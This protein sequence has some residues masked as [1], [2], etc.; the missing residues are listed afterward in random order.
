MI[1]LPLYV[2]LLLD[3]LK[4]TKYENIKVLGAIIVASPGANN[5]IE[6]FP[7]VT[8]GILVVCLGNVINLYFNAWVSS[9][10]ASTIGIFSIIIP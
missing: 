3:M 1:Q 4:G 6:V 8:T 9:D 2:R 10:T 7:T 5:V